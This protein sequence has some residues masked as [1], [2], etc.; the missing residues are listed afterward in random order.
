LS[1]SATSGDDSPSAT[2]G[3][4]SIAAAIGING[5][6]KASKGSWIVCA[7]YRQRPDCTWEVRG[8]KTAKVDGERLKADT[9][10]ELKGGKFVEAK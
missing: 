10:Y 1:P 9:Y 6:A 5:K 4:D 8:V 2:S 3:A 7:E